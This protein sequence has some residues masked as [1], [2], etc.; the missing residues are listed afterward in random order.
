MWTV[1]LD[2]FLNTFPQNLQVSF[3]LLLLCIASIPPFFA[4]SL[5]RLGSILGN[6]VGDARNKGAPLSRAL[7]VTSSLSTSS[8]DISM[9]VDVTWGS[10]LMVRSAGS[11]SCFT[12]KLSPL[13]TRSRAGGGMFVLSSKG[14]PAAS[15]FIRW[16]WV[17][18]WCFWGLGRMGGRRWRSSGL[19]LWQILMRWISSTCL[20]SKSAEPSPA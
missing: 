2:V 9:E 16:S 18:W 20:I 12:C 8:S 7:S 17:A 6:W 3:L 13:N 4:I 15:V 1:K 5:S 11:H 10:H 14:L 19:S